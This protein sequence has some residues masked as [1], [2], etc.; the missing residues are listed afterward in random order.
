MK[1][2]K[3]NILLL[4]V[5]ALFLGACSEFLDTNPD[6]RLT[7]EQVKANPALAEGWILKAYKGL[8]T[9]YDFDE[10]AA[11][12]DAVT[13]D[14][15]S[16]I[17]TMNTGGW[18]SNNNPVGIWAKAYEMN[19]YLNT[20][21]MYA[22]EIEY[23]WESEVRNDLFR[24]KLKGEAHALRAYWNT[25]LLMKHAGEGTN[26]ELLG[27][28]IVNKVIG[29]G[30]DYY[31]PRNS[32]GACV[33]YILEDLDYAIDSLPLRWEDSGD[34]DYNAAMGARFE[35]RMNG[36]A[37]M[38]IKSRLL[39]F[40]ASPAFSESGYT[41]QE[42]AEA[43]A[44]VMAENGGVSELN[45]SDLTWYLDVT[46]SE[47]I[48][49]SAKTD[50]T[51]KW[52]DSQFPPSLYGDGRVNPSQNLIDA[53]PMADGTPI[54]LSGSY[55]QNAPYVGRDPRLAKYVVV[56]GASFAGG[57]VNTYTGAGVDAPAAVVTSSRT[58]YYLRKFMNESVRINPAQ[59]IIGAGHFYTYARYTEAL[60]NF[61]EAA[62]EA[63][64]PDQEVDGYSAREVINALRNRAGISDETYVNSITS[65]EGMRELIRNE[66]RIELCFEGF[67]FW[68]IRRWNLTGVMAESVDGAVISADQSTVTTAK[69]EDRKYLPYQVYGPIPYSE[70]LKYD[71]IQ[72]QSW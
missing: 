20:F 14:V 70:T 3:I 7:L 67:R 54:S 66:R 12:D 51:H 62:N 24:Q 47:I 71:I 26:G 50:N 25:L 19:M 59:T 72:N 58:S 48:W 17:I 53:F 34:F 35:N 65:K 27:F 44:A 2:K 36:L 52:E 15:S 38:L 40:A 41:M 61:A 69:V 30:D 4:G 16:N 11:C 10:D 23:S 39:L 43:A 42:A 46:S 5:A 49:N 22:D 21:L 33:E 60:L 64:G 1:M 28:P 63:V 37:A 57:T 32:F 31:L 55:N 68:D 8:P 29:E 9:D 45:G 6:N 13:N 56:N 18:T